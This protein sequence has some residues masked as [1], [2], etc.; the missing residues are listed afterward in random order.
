[1]GKFITNYKKTSLMAW[2]HCFQGDVLCYSYPA[3]V[4]DPVQ[5]TLL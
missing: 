4:F 3:R 5:P 2:K 1:M